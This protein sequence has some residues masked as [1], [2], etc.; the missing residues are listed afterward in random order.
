[1][2]KT[3][4]QSFDKKILNKY[5]TFQFQEWNNKHPIG[6][7]NQT[8]GPTDNIINFFDQFIKIFKLFLLLKKIKFPDS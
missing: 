4:Y 1:M 2:Q 8:L 3:S 6:I 7:L 5:V